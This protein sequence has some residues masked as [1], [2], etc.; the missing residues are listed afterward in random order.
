MGGDRE[1]DLV[2][3]FQGEGGLR[4]RE[5]SGGF[6]FFFVIN[7]KKIG[8]LKNTSHKSK[9]YVLKMVR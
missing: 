9:Y 8:V 7:R 4:G 6:F 3:S 5:S 1:R 2:G